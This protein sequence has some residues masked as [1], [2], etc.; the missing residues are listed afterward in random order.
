MKK[1]DSELALANLIEDVMKLACLPKQALARLDRFARHHGI[2]RAE[3]IRR[4]LYRGLDRF[5]RKHPGI[6]GE[7]V[8]KL[9]PPVDPPDSTW[10]VPSGS[11]QPP[12]AIR[13]SSNT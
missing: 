2:P 1:S 3:A 6:D 10:M 8:M 11:M 7:V 4:L 5:E 9:I 12:P 13:G